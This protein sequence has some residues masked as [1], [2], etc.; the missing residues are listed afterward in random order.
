MNT[1]SKEEYKVLVEDIN[2]KEVVFNDSLMGEIDAFYEEGAFD[3]T[4]SAG[5]SVGFFKFLNIIKEFY[6]RAY[7]VMYLTSLDKLPLDI[8]D[9]SMAIIVRWRLKIGK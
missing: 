4:D 5:G 8:N 2:C 3:Y 9:D 6:P 1:Y 7:Q